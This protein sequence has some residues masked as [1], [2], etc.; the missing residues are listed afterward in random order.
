M[1]RVGGGCVLAEPGAR[2][3]GGFLLGLLLHS[4]PSSSSSFSLLSHHFPP[5]YPPF[6]L[7]LLLSLLSCLLVQL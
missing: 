5:L 7:I 4:P 6:P 2:A 3:E 1:A